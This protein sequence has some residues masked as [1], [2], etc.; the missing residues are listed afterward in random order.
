MD[1]LKWTRRDNTVNDSWMNGMILV[2]GSD[3]GQ[4][5]AERSP[6]SYKVSNRV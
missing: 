2:D 1:V 5:D 3:D 6:S 4:Q